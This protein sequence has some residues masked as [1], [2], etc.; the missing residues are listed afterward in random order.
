MRVD[1]D[2]YFAGTLQADTLIPSVGCVENEHLADGENFEADKFQHEHRLA[3]FFPRSVADETRPIHIFLYSGEVKTIRVKFSTAHV[4]ESTCSIDLK[5][6]GSSILS[7]PISTALADGVAVKRG[8][9]AANTCVAGDVITVVL[10]ATVGT[11]TL[12]IGLFVEIGL[13][14]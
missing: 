6:N 14:E 5:K 9:V 7:A 11:G 10:D 13:W 2:A 3:A 12:G 8:T 4:G 1:E